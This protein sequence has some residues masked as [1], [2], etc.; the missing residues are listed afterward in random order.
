METQRR[1]KS[2]FNIHVITAFLSCMGL[3]VVF[4]NLPPV[5][6]ELRT[7]Y[8]VTYASIGF[9]VTSLV[10]AHAAVQIPSGLVTD[11]IGPKKALLWSLSLILVSTLFC[12]FNK[13]YYF[14]LFLRILGG[15]GTGFAFISGMKY[16]ALFT[17]ESRRGLVQ[18]IFGGSFSVGGIFPFLLMPMLVQINWKLI[19]LTTA[20]FFA[21]PIFLLVLWGKEVR[22]GT[23]IKLAQFKPVFKTEAI[24]MLGALHAIFF[25]GVLTMSTW[26]SAFFNSIS[27]KDSLISTGAWGALMMLI[28]GI[29]RFMGGELMKMFTPLNMLIY[30]FLI[31][32]VSYMMLWWLHNFLL[33]LF[34][35]SLAIYMSSVTFGPIFFLSSVA[36]KM[37]FAASGFGIVNFIANLGSFLLPILFGY[38]IDISGSYLVSFVFM[39]SLTVIGALMVYSLKRLIPQH[40]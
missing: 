8:G 23:E 37:E 32:A 4:M 36:S 18:G 17:P 11:V 14:V 38:F 6:P 24:W 26:F 28:S 15:I 29:A 1:E 7:A 12:V 34:F 22:S 35:F 5:L 39:S 10:L 27:N 21:I 2:A 13:H 31:L 40:V 20:C 3:G 19:Y 33:L 30:S 25:G 16:A 9:L